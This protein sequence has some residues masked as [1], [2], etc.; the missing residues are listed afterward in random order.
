MKINKNNLLKFLKLVGISGEIENKEA[1]LSIE[2]KLLKVLTLSTGKYVIFYGFLKDNFEKIEDIGID[3]IQELIEYITN[4]E[5]ETINLIKK[6]N[7]LIFDS[8][9]RLTKEDK[10][11]ISYLLKNP[12]YIVNKLEINKYNEILKKAQGNEFTPSKKI[13]QKII[14]YSDSFKTNNLILE[15]YNKNKLSLFIEDSSENNLLAEFDVKVNEDFNIK[16]SKILIDIFKIIDLNDN[17]E[18]SIKNDSPFKIRV[19]NDNYEA[20]YLI[21][22]LKK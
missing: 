5:N 18:L 13:L 10:L 17:I 16:I 12:D 9:D 20:I 8:I 2:D 15:T 6:E 21:A 14:S 22:L 11:K 1:L 19:Y 3:N 4:F 7:K